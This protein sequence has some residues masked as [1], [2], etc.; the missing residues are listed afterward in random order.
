MRSQRR[1]P[2]GRPGPRHSA[3]PAAAPMTLDIVSSWQQACGIA[4]Y[5]S[6]LYAAPALRPHVAMIMAQEHGDAGDTTNAI[7]DRRVSRIW[8]DNLQSMLTLAK[9]LE[10]GTADVIWFQ[11]HPGHFSASDMELLTQS[12]RQ[13]RYGIKAVT[14]HSVSEA[15]RGGDLCWTRAF[16]IAFV[17]SAEDATRLSEAGHRNPVVVPHGFVISASDAPKPDPAYFTIGSFG[18]LN[19]HKNIDLLV[20]AF[21]VARR[22]EPRLRLSLF[23]CEQ[24]SDQSR[25]SRVVV[26]NLIR[27][28]GLA[29]HVSACF[30]FIA[31][32]DLLSCLSTCD[33]FVFP[34]GHSTE[35]ATGAARIA[36]SADRPILCSR[37]PVLRDL[38]PASH[39]LK[40]IDRECIAEALVSL[41]QSE[42]VLNLHDDARRDLVRRYSYDRAARRYAGHLNRLLGRK[43]DHRN[44]A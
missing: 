23:N 22:F 44:A 41:A 13:S 25:R 26:E 24:R 14:I 42:D 31:E 10:Q 19:P 39:V 37:S 7:L 33:M 4:T 28:Y 1:K 2:R 15:A 21:A 17:H 12:I 36:L 43:R 8:G 38:W 32:D 9:R 6:H 29:D 16:D 18:F 35:T 3:L 30:D 34:Y 5:S 27:H 40:S 20:S 11:H